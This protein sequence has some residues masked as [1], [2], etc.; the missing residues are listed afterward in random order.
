MLADPGAGPPH[1]DFQVVGLGLA[2]ALGGAVARPDSLAVA[3]LGD[4]RALMSLSELETVSRLGPRM[5]VVVYNDA[6]MRPRCTTSGA[7]A[8]RSTWSASP[9]PTSPRLA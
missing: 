8:I 4:G 5:L 6:A 7:R 3:A 9:I 2:T 1:L